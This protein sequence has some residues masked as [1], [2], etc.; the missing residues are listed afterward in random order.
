M[1]GCRRTMKIFIRLFLYFALIV[2]LDTTCMVRVLCLQLGPCYRDML[3]DEV[4][5]WSNKDCPYNPLYGHYHMYH[6]RY[7]CSRLDQGSLLAFQ[8]KTVSDWR[9]YYQESLK[10]CKEYA[11]Q[12]HESLDDLELR[13]RLYILHQYNFY[14]FDSFR[15]FIRSFGEQYDRHI[16]ELQATFGNK[17]FIDKS[18]LRSL[19]FLQGWETDG[20]EKFVASEFPECKKRVDIIEA[21]F[22]AN[23]AFDEERER[24]YIKW[25]KSLQDSCKSGF[26]YRGPYNTTDEVNSFLD[27]GK[28]TEANHCPD[29]YRKDFVELYGSGGITQNGKDSVLEVEKDY[30]ISKQLQDFLEQQKMDNMAVFTRCHGVERQHKLHVQY[31]ESLEKI[32]NL[33]NQHPDNDTLKGMA[34]RVVQYAYMG[35]ALNQRKYKNTQ[36]E[37]GAYYLMC[38]CRDL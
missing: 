33:Q 24:L 34:K 15:E 10:E 30:L 4:A 26:N 32:V 35:L 6:Q 14:Q 17:P 1:L 11:L 16:V 29:R 3:Y 22:R 38:V 18:V 12:K 27:L 9:N 37:K 21:P 23:V 36:Y 2:S 19:R 8:A 5:R 28:L 20:F 7:L 13:L 31:L 25:T